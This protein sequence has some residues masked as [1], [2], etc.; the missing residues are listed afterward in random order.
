MQ[1]V[2]DAA[3]LH[4]F[5]AREYGTVA[6][7]FVVERV[8]PGELDVRLKVHP[9][10]D[11]RPGGTVSGPV[12]FTLADVA[13]YLITLA[14]VG[15]EALAVTVNATIDYMRKPAPVDLIARTR[16]LK[17]GRA[18]SVSDMLLYSVGHEKPVARASLTYSLPPRPV[19]G[20]GALPV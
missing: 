1:P 20:E 17:L 2:M 14:H 10:L 3:A 7:R 11:I 16:L 4:D 8:A 19:S 9:E 13:A 15:P 5:M 12:M 18:L 6:D